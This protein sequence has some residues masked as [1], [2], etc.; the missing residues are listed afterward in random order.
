MALR[1]AVVVNQAPGLGGNAVGRPSTNR[2]CKRFGARFLG[3]VEVTEA[4]GQRSDNP[5]HS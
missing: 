2:H 5:A 1:L 3:D 4:P